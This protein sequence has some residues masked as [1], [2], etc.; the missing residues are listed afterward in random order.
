MILP[1]TYQNGFAP[2]DGQPLY[3]SLWKGCV[4]AWNPGL[5]PSGLTLR[6]NSGFGNDGT[7]TN[8]PTF[9]AS[10]GKYAITSD[11]VNDLIKMQN[12]TACN[13]G[14]SDATIV[15][16]AVL[17][18]TSVFGSILSKRNNGGVFQQYQLL[19]GYINNSFATVT[20]KMVSCFFYAGGA[21][22]ASQHVYTSADVIDGKPHCIAV[23]RTNG[24]I[25][26]IFVDG[27]EVAT[28]VVGSAT[29]NQNGDSSTDPLR[30][31]A[32]TDSS[33]FLA[34]TLSDV[35]IY[36]R[37]LSPNE[38]RTLATRP[39]IAYEMAPR[40]RSSVQVTTNRRRR[41]IIGGNR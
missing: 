40:R 10:Q 5:G 14:T 2:R 34:M 30:L 19:Q 23:S 12:L 21:I 38:I 17:P 15:L 32:G 22:G 1:A 18:D 4:G 37:A 41:I 20:G 27:V 33:S 6:D 11:G 25:P 29:T 3:P 35:R 13:L 7:L 8:G 9:A 26:K 36:N 24:S 28:T 16:H 39:G 31:F